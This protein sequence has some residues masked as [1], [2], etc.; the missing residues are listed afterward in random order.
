MKLNLVFFG[1][2]IGLISGFLLA[3]FGIN[4][5]IET[6]STSIGTIFISG[7]IIIAALV[8]LYLG[9][10]N[11]ISY[12]FGPRNP[13]TSD[14]IG[15]VNEVLSEALPQLSDSGRNKVMSLGQ[16]IS[17]KYSAWKLRVLIVNAIWGLVIVFGG[18][19]ATFVLLKQ[20]E[21]IKTQNTFLNREIILQGAERFSVYA[22]IVNEVLAEIAQEGIQH[23]ARIDKLQQESEDGLI[24]GTRLSEEH[25][26][27]KDDGKAVLSPE[28]EA[29]IS[30][31]L[32][33]LEPYPYL[34]TDRENVISGDI[35]ASRV[36][37]LSPERGNILHS[38]IR[39]DFDL[40]Q[41]ENRDFSFADL[42]G[43]DFQDSLFHN[44]IMHVYEGCSHEP[45][46]DLSSVDLSYSDFSGAKFAQVDFWIQDGMVLNGATFEASTVNIGGQ[47]RPSLSNVSF[48]DT[49]VINMSG[50]LEH[51][52]GR[53]PV[54]L[55]GLELNLGLFDYPVGCIGTFVNTSIMTEAEI[56]PLSVSGLK[57][58][59]QIVGEITQ[60]QDGDF[61]VIWALFEHARLTPDEYLPKELV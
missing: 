17:A 5:I 30:A 58:H 14:G 38:L 42:R 11:L 52:H 10:D 46:Y 39:H 43:K 31:L 28:L 32:A 2:F 44:Y 25:I 1:L 40:G 9:L 18:V 12:L 16:N 61:N 48:S 56:A 54:D 59:I 34:D 23:S 19:V 20:N 37:Y 51:E 24:E 60:P 35:A 13:P 7:S 29:K 49:K 3:N 15:M 4:L 47:H 45:V 50:V 27:S 55:E 57:F 8:C 21:L 41:M 33:Q 6:I 22:P 26:A 53:T 36:F